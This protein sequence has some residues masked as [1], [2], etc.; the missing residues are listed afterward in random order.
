MKEA[1]LGANVSPSAETMFQAVVPPT[2]F[3][4]SSVQSKAAPPHGWTSIP[5]CRLYQS[6]R[7]CG[8]SALKKM[9]PIPVTR[10][11]CTS[12]IVDGNGQNARGRL[13]AALSPIGLAGVLRVSVRPLVLHLERAR[14]DEI[15][16]HPL[17]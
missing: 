2:A 13:S 11:M 8:S 10:F 16:V 4:A 5:R 12:R 6:C 7:A 1:V 3:P 9:P 17:R 15:Q 14:G